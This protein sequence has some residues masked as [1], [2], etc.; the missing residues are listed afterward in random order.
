MMRTMLH[1]LFT[2]HIIAVVVAIGVI[3]SGTAPG[4]AAKNSMPAGMSA[5][6]GMAMQ[7]DCMDAVKHDGSSKDMP[8]KTTDNACGM[9]ATCGVPI[10]EALL[11]ERLSRRGETVFT[12]DVSRS[13]I[14]TLPALPPPIA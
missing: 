3:L 8:G 14:A 4:W 11:S 1:R 7:N 12:H 6:P 5:M 13:G 9:C 2:R 10:S